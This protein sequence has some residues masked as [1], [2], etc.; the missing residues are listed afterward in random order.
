MKTYFDCIPCFLKQA[1]ATAR[2]VSSDERIHEGMLR[3]MLREVSEMDLTMP[4][5]IMG[6]RIHRLIRELTTQSDPYYER[7]QYFNQFAL[8]LLPRLKR[9][10]DDAADPLECAV[11]LAIAG[12]II[13][14]GAAAT[15]EDES[16]HASIE[17]SLSADISN[18][19]IELFKQ[20]INEAKT[21]LFLGDNAGEIVFDQLLLSQMPLDKVVYVVK[22]KPIINDATMEDALETGLTQMVR[23]VGN[24]SDAPGCILDDCSPIFRERFASADLIIAKGQANYETLSHIR[25]PIFFLLQAKCPVIA[26]DIGCKT[27]DFILTGNYD[28]PV[29]TNRA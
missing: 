17:K 14:F 15:V 11:R 3:N 13:D 1:L 19:A 10:V 12:N 16:V 5:P 25:K 27:G 2:F 18:A 29:A 24:G 6:Q 21:I 8:R 4:P 28:A 23:V 9:Y 26:R 7:K 20:A 22:G